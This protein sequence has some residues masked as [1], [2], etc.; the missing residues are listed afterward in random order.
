MAK[1]LGYNLKTL[2]YFE[3]LYRLLG[4]V[5][6]YPFVS[7]LFYL[8]I[9]WSPFVYITNRDLLQYLVSPGTVILL[10][11]I[12]LIIVV[13]FLIEILFLQIIFEYGIKEIQLNMKYLWLAGVD[14]IKMMGKLIPI[15]LWVPTLSFVYL[16]GFISVYGFASSIEL[17]ILVNEL[18]A[19]V[20]INRV[21]LGFTAIIFI[22]FVETMLYLPIYTFKKQPFKLVNLEKKMMLSQRRIRTMVEFFSINFLLNLIV[23]AFYLFII[24]A[25]GWLIQLTRGEGY[26]VPT[27]F[28]FIYAVY[29]LI[30]FLS[31]LFFVPI[32]VAYI[33]AVYHNNN[34]EIVTPETLDFYIMRPHPK[35]TKWTRK[36]AI[37]SIV[38]LIGLNIGT[39]YQ[40]LG[41]DRSPLELLNRSAVIAHRG[42]SIYAPE[43]TLAA[44]D[45]A[46]AQ[47]ADAVEID[48]RMSKDGIPF[49]FHDYTVNRTTNLKTSQSIENL[50]FEEIQNLDAG[51][52][53]HPDF[54]G[55]KI[56]SLAQVL[57]LIYGRTYL[58]LEIKGS[59]PGIETR[60]ME[61]LM[62]Y[63]MVTST[64]IMSF[65]RE[66][67][68][69]VKSMDEQVTTMLLI[70]VFVGSLNGVIT[71]DYVDSLGLRFDMIKT[72]PE[73]I[74]MIHKA[75]KRAYVWTLNRADDIKFAVNIDADG[76]ITDD[77]LLALELVYEKWTPTL[78]QDLIR[79]L[80]NKV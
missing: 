40:I 73:Y 24:I 43:N 26:V 35:Q 76:I 62:D 23:Y 3:I 14:Q 70:P 8:T 32:N 53:F 54:A 52:W 2:I 67:L 38:V 47:G 44:M 29:L 39:V 17:P 51:S 48:V 64:T 46:I 55:E 57:E 66:Q 79:R 60:V 4:V 75:D 63:D 9:E 20:W 61:M 5:L 77:P 36:V 72:N 30:G 68:R 56:P 13:Y 1:G 80:F 58:Y 41:A 22:L 33:T 71:L 15:Y 12:V 6:V 7:R 19:D 27:L 34:A 50:T 69:K 49:L 37:I 25:L 78:L 59:T 11:I 31:T 16:T 45:L 74:E 28:T 10:F 21:V 65:N 18:R 42:A